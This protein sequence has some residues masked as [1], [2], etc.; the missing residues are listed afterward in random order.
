M[1]YWLGVDAG[2]ERGVVARQQAAEKC[3]YFHPEYAKHLKMT[4]LGTA[5]LD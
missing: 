1:L 3:D 2:R 5:I 4:E